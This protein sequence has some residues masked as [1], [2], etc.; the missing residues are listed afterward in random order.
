[1]DSRADRPHQTAR[2]TSLVAIVAYEPGPELA[3]LCEV[4]VRTHDVLIIDNASQ[5]GTDVLAQCRRLGA[6]VERL[7]S[8]SGIAGG[9]SA[10]LA[11]AGHR[12]WLVTLDQ[13]SVIGPDFLPT[14]L[15]EAAI[16][17]AD[18]AMI[19]P[20]VVEVGTGTM[21]QGP[22]GGGE[23]P[24]LITSGTANRIPALRSV[25]G[26]RADLFIDHVDHD[27]CLRLRRSG[28]RI[29]LADG[30][31][32]RHS[33]GRTRA[34]RR[35]ALT[36]RATHHG[37]DRHYYRYR[38]F[39]LLLR[40]GTARSDPRWAMRVALAHA[41]GPA[42]V[43]AVESGRRDKLIAAIEGLRDGM[44]GRTGPRGD[45]PAASRE[46]TPDGDGRTR[47]ALLLC[48][49][50]FGYYRDIAR[51]LAA[52]GYT[53]DHHDDRPGANPLV[54]GLLKVRP[55]LVQHVVDRYLDRLRVQTRGRNYDLIVVVNGKVLD[56]RF[57]DDLLEDNPTAR[58]VLYLWDSIDLYPHVLGF[59]DRFDQRFTFDGRDAR[60]R[61]QFDLLPLFFTDSYRSIGAEDPPSPD[62][63]LVNVCTAHPNRY[64]LMQRVLPQL[65]A[66]G[67]HVYSWL[68]LNP[69]AFAHGRL[70]APELARAHRRDFHFRPL[71]TP[72][73][74]DVLRR[75]RGVFDVSHS[76]QTG[77]TMRTI[78][79]IGARRKLVTTNQEVLTYPFYD[80]TRVLVFDPELTTPED[81]RDFLASPQKPL[82]P[83]T[84]EQ[85]G[86]ASW[87]DRIVTGGRSADGPLLHR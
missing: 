65:A 63:D 3:A 77:L 15:A 25:G 17:E 23:V 55:A 34:H 83:Q 28:W 68:Y 78:E 33:I 6:E 2:G 86:I 61:P 56:G 46:Q 75:S 82:D 74:L 22:R 12:E 10:A 80:V 35:G 38:N 16:A 32:M 40:D 5:T 76:R 72:A 7:P 54:K 87:V 44:R 70:T 62:Y 66:V 37:A 48:A 47:R 50:F 36:L 42:K 1:M 29:R 4:A 11:R 52:S 84:Y 85:F 27:A 8:N 19:G 53:V 57:V 60:D 51:E 69:L 41:W 67:L 24:F 45:P 18:V 79:T 59:A 30:V 21:V 9:L 39:V 43:L 73:Y 81:V 13:D 14:L 71:S 58:S 49:P 31:S 64:A 20:E 26:F